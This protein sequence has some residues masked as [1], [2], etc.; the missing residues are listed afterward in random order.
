[1]TALG[2]AAAAGRG[3]ILAMLHLVRGALV[4][5]H[6]AQVSAS[7]TDGAGG[8]TGAR[9]H[10]CGQSAQL[11]AVD[12]KGNAARHHLDVLFLQAGG[13]AHI[14]R[15][16]TIIAGFDTRLVL[17]LLHCSLLGLDFGHVNLARATCT[18]VHDS[19]SQSGVEGLVLL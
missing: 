17:L 5:A 19:R 2:R 9:H 6:V 8:L 18:A 1:L 14:T 7:L 11:G 4:R 15:I 12:V 3:A 16:R 10:A 13:R